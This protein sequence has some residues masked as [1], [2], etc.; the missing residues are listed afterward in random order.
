V[1]KKQRRHRRVQRHWS[2]YGIGERLEEVAL[3]LG[4]EEKDEMAGPRSEGA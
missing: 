1:W 2:H 3:G 4:S